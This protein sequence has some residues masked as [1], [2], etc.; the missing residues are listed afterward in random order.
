MPDMF[1]SLKKIIKFNGQ[2]DQE[3]LYFEV[4]NNHYAMD[5][6]NLFVFFNTKT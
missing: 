4:F 2:N 6:V 5:D 1:S 3:K